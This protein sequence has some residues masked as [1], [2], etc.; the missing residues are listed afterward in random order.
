MQRTSI[1]VRIERLPRWLTMSPR[2]RSFI[3]VLPAFV[4]LLI[5]FG[6][7]VAR[8]LVMSILDKGQLTLEFYERVFSTR[9]YITVIWNTMK[10]GFYVTVGA[11]ILGY[12]AAYFLT[13]APPKIARFCF[14]CVMLPFWTSILVRTYAWMVLLGRNGVINQLLMAIKLTDAPVTLMYNFFGVSV[15]MLQVLLPF[16]ILPM[17]SVM[18]RIDINLVRAAEVL[19]ANKLR[20]FIYVYFPLSLPGVVAGSLLVFILALGFYI[21]PAFLG[22]GRVI[23][24][25]PLIEQQVRQLGNWGFA[26]ALSFVLLSIAL[27]IFVVYNRVLGWEKTWV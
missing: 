22:G 25:A 13:I 7:P 23:M 20:A 21:T 4:F 18:S 9:L 12:P 27:V 6:Y 5:L 19:G 26:S 10:M 14:F 16:M 15:G 3:P 1:P 8:L 2:L 24:I 17:Y 11:F